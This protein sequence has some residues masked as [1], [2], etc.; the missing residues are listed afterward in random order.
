ML[1]YCAK[2]GVRIDEYQ[3]EIIKKRD[4]LYIAKYQG[5]APSK[6][7][8]ALYEKPL[9]EKTCSAGEKAPLP[10]SIV[11]IADSLGAL[12]VNK[13]DTR[14][15][16]IDKKETCENLYRLSKRDPEEIREEAVDRI[17]NRIRTTAY[18]LAEFTSSKLDPIECEN[19]PNNRDPLEYV[20]TALTY[21]RDTKD[22]LFCFPSFMYE[23]IKASGFKNPITNEDITV[24]ARNKIE[25]Q[26]EMF[27]KLK[28]NPNRV[29][30]VGV[31]A[32]I[33]QEKDTINNDNTNYA[34]NTIVNMF[35]ARGVPRTILE[36]GLDIDKYNQILKIIGMC[37]GYLKELEKS[38]QFATFC[39]AM[40][41]YL[42][43]NVEQVPYVLN[44]ITVQKAT[45]QGPKSA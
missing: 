45:I 12:K 27:E 33:L 6:Q 21:Y 5:Q 14:E 37:Q 34:I 23:D 40:Y 28:I 41:S 1:L 16:V 9:F 35:Q 32:D 43:K 26:L 10:K 38:H 20:D 15:P 4:D 19:K 42:K 17:K 31:A 11:L 13:I 30:S 29:M 3:F 24:E 44:A 7:I 2:Y 18:T 39:K 25:N 8:K 22:R 36:K